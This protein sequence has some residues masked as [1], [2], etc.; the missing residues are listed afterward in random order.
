MRNCFSRVM[1]RTH[2]DR[3]VPEACFCVLT[4][5]KGECLL[6]ARNK[7]EQHV[8]PLCVLYPDTSYTVHVCMEAQATQCNHCIAFSCPRRVGPGLSCRLSSYATALICKRYNLT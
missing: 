6:S 3:I 1:A 8:Y 7:P 5:T 2:G 4:A